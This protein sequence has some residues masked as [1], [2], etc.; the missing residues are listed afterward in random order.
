MCAVLGRFF[1]SPFTPIDLRAFPTGGNCHNCHNRPFEPA[2]LPATTATMAPKAKPT[3]PAWRSKRPHNYMFNDEAH[4]IVC[5]IRLHPELAKKFVP[6]IDVDLGTNADDILCGMF[7]KLQ[8][9]LV[10]VR[11]APIATGTRTEKGASLFDIKTRLGRPCKE[12]QAAEAAARLVGQKWRL[13]KQQQARKQR[14]PQAVKAAKAARLRVGS[15]TS[16]GTAIVSAKESA[17][18]QVLARVRVLCARYTYT[19][20]SYLI[21]DSAI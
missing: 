17:L 6:D 19:E 18:V 4:A 2:A 20:H 10:R 11:D 7:R 15:F 8:G 5:L 3:A 14:V 9:E 12:A 21:A 16:R 13:H 1:R